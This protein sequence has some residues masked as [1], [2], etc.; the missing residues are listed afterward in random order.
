MQD[1]TQQ[2]T[3]IITTTISSLDR[4]TN[5]KEGNPRYRIFTPAQPSPFKTSAHALGT[6][7][8]PEHAPHGTKAGQ[9]IRLR[10]NQRE[11]IVEVSE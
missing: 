9:P 2:H 4:L 5:T 10:I 7:L 8:L 6:H 3:S 11:R 1:T